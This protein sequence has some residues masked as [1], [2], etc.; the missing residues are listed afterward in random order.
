MQLLGVGTDV[1]FLAS[2]PDRRGVRSGEPAVHE[3]TLVQGV[4]ALELRQSGLRLQIIMPCFPRLLH[5]LATLSLDV[6]V[7][8]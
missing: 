3:F 2:L 4:Q 8:T 7:I 5:D 6:C 1:V